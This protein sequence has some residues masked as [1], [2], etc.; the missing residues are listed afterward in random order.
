MCLKT[1]VSFFFKSFYLLIDLLTYLFKFFIDL[2]L[3]IP[4]TFTKKK[5]RHYSTIENI[6]NDLLDKDCKVKHT[7][8][9]FGNVI[10]RDLE[11]CSK[12]DVDK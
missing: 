7:A 5:I 1:R 4:R 10:F 12:L 3:Y 6:K 11:F 2:L 9:F 8:Y